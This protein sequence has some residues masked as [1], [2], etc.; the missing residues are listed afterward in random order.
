MQLAKLVP[1]CW[2]VASVGPLH[3]VLHAARAL[4]SPPL[5]PELLELLDVLEPPRLVHPEVSGLPMLL[6]FVNEAL[7]GQSKVT[8]LIEHV[9]D[10]VEV[11]DVPPPDVPPPDDVVPPPDD[12]LPELLPPV[13][14]EEHATCA[15]AA[16]IRLEAKR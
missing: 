1:N 2:Q 5:V 10:D 14:S 6:H 15:T 4:S 9:K 8:P 3:L 16:R 7:S 11:P 12:V 13:S